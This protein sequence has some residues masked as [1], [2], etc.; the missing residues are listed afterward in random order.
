MLRVAAAV[1]LIGSAA[2]AFA[3]VSPTC[4]DGAVP[5]A[6]TA[7]NR[8]TGAQLRAA[9]SGKRLGYVR[10]SVRHP[11]VWVNNS[12]ELRADGSM[13]YRCGYSRSQ[14]G[15]WQPCPSYGSVEHQRAGARD[16]GVWRISGDAV[17]AT[18]ASFSKSSEDCFAIHRQGGRFA[19]KRVSGPVSACLQGE[20]T[21]QNP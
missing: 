4:R 19:A 13:V 2:S 17:C 10:E 16:V 7:A 3:A 1:V 9:V 20:V 14:S 11:G 5:F 12:R 15:P 6:P 21:L 18:H 8:L